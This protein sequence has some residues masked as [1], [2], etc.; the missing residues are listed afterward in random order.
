MNNT[1]T[2]NICTGDVWCKLIEHP[3]KTE[4]KMNY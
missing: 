3:K 4:K 1:N 2:Y